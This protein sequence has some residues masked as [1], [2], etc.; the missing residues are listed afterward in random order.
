MKTLPI[1]TLPSPIL[2]EKSREVAMK[3]LP[4]LHGFID[5]LVAT[6]YANDGI[7]IAAPQVG[8]SLRII[9]IG[10]EKSPLVLVNPVI[11]TSSQETGWG[12]EGCL[13]VPGIFGKVRR[14]KKIQVKA[15]DPSGKALSLKASFLLARVIQHEIDHINGILFIDKME[16]AKGALLL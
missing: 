13:S 3:E 6:M 12:E 8:T 2:R 15:L 9:V 14:A 10:T 5:T 1:L 16:R 4:R 11:H 7:G